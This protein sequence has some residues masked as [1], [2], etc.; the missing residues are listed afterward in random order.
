MRLLPSA[1]NSRFMSTLIITCLK[2]P[3]VAQLLTEMP[4]SETHTSM[5]RNGS[6]ACNSW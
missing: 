6:A 2:G 1:S 5:L 4:G 3:G